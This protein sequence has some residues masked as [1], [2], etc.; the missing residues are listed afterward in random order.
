MLNL[1]KS[2]NNQRK[3]YRSL[4]AAGLLCNSLFQFVAPVLAEGTKAG[5]VISN[6]ATAT[7]EDGNGQTL[8]ATSNTVTVTVAEVAGITITGNS[9]VDENQGTVV[10]GDQ[11]F[12]NFRVNNVGN[13]PTKF[14][15]PASN[16]VGITG[17]GTVLRLEYSL[18]GTDGWTTIN[19]ADTP[20]IAADGS[21]FVRAVVTVNAGASATQVIRVTL[22]NTGTSTN[23]QNQ[24]RI[25]NT[26]DVY[27]V[28]NTGTT[29][30]DIAG[31]P[32]NLVREA[33]AFVEATVNASSYAFAKVLKTSSGVNDGGT[34]KINDD[35]LSYNLSLEVQSTDPTN[36]GINPAA[37]TGT[38]IKGFNEPRILV[39]DA[40]PLDTQLAVVPTAP[41]GWQAVY[42][43][44]PISTN[45]NA[46]TWQVLTTSTNLTTVTR[47]GFVNNPAASVTSVAPNSPAINF[48]IQVKVRSTFTGTS[49]TVSNI[50]QLFGQSNGVENTDTNEDGIPDRFIYDESGDQNPSNYNGSTPPGTDAND[51]GIPDADPTPIDDGYIN[52][53]AD[54]TTT[55]TDTGNNNT[56]AGP[57]GE[58]SSTVVTQITATVQNGPE[59][60]P[61]AIGPG[62]NPNTDFTNKSSAIAANTRPGSTVDPAVVTFNNTLTNASTQANDISLLPTPPANVADLPPTTTVTIKY[63]NQEKVYTWSGTEFLLSDGSQINDAADY[64]TIPNVPVNGEID[65]SVEVNLPSGTNLSADDNILRGYPVPITAFVDDTIAG[66]GAET[67]RNTTI[68]RVYTGFLKLVK[69]SRVL[70]GT[71]PAVGAGQGDFNSTPAFDP[72]GTGGPLPSIDPNPNVADVARTPA[73]GNVIEYRIRY[74]N[75][76]EVQP[77]DGS[78]NSILTANN[79]VITE[80]GA[81]ST[82][83]GDGLNNWALDRDNNNQIDT[84]NVPGSAT[85]SSVGVTINFFKGNTTTNTSDLDVTRYVDNAGN[86][87]PGGERTFIF[88]RRVN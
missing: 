10:S 19:D 84:S 21:I 55:G 34:A 83:V 22:G 16:N 15:I 5:E 88:Q 46:A 39:S 56:G 20:S 53:D 76:S 43:T 37:L 80:D 45:A 69:E 86:V 77:T 38:L 73:Q 42:T 63:L 57:G 35:T 58:A 67:G 61:N 75:I 26:G 51:D 87:A 3:R 52:N 40:I 1:N 9:F 13:D 64:I 27:T 54:L 79:V 60:F 68:D 50:A 11:L 2:A 12:Y 62:N 25:D 29:N 32:A 17:P 4:I 41:A 85:D 48:S 66:L 24:L 72:D 14:H 33:S 65:Y 82:T 81:L 49:L 23:T 36:K 70:Q 59:D 71:G 28:D 7:Y 18:N 74:S 47:V 30:G 8:N 31:D 6:T 44:D 78:N